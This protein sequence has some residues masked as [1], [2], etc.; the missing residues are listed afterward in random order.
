M[1]K[2]FLKLSSKAMQSDFTFWR[3]ARIYHGSGEVRTSAAGGLVVK[4]SQGETSYA[5]DMHRK[6]KD[7][8]KYS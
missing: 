1:N 3:K 7:A 6:S 4:K 2:R 8:D 5:I